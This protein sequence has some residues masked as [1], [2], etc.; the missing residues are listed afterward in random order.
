MVDYGWLMVDGGCWMVVGLGWRQLGM[1]FNVKG[2]G[3][4]ALGCTVAS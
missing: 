3:L 4:R 2:H 1:W